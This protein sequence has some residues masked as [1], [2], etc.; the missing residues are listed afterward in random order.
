M[1]KIKR[2]RKGGND[3][4]KKSDGKRISGIIS[5]S[6]VLSFFDKLCTGAHEKVKTGLFAR[7]FCSYPE[8]KKVKQKL[9]K[10]RT[11]RSKV[12]EKIENSVLTAFFSKLLV[13]FIEC[14][15][16]VY[17]SFLFA[18]SAVSGV[19]TLVT[20]LM[21][22]RGVIPASSYSALIFCGAVLI[23]S[24]P[25]ISSRKTLLQG[26]K[27]SK[28][29]LKILPI[30]GFEPEKSTYENER[31]KSLVGLLIGILV[32]ALIVKISPFLIICGLLA[33]VYAIMVIC[34]PEFGVLCL[35]FVSP[36]L[37]TMPVA[38]LLILVVIS[39]FLKII[40]G[41][42][43]V[44]FETVDLFVLIF[45]GLTLFGGIV[46]LSLESLAPSLMRLCLILGFF[47]V[48]SVKQSR[49]WLKKYAISAIA[50]AV[51]VSLYGIL[52]YFIGSKVG[53]AWLDTSMFTDIS[54]RAIS[55]LENPN[56]LGEYLIMIIPIALASLISGELF[57]RSQIFFFTLIMGFCLIL[58]W[59]RGAW[60]GL[61][62]AA[63]IL[64]FIWHKRAMWLVFGSLIAFPLATFVMPSSILNRFMSIGNTADSSTLYRVN[65]WRGAMR[66][67]R[68]NIFTGI[69]IGE[70]A[71]GKIYPDY[72]LPGIEQAPHSHNLF[73][74]ITV[75]MGIIA[76]IVFLFVLFFTYQSGFTLFSKL[77]RS[78]NVDPSGLLSPASL[79]TAD[80]FKVK[81]KKHNPA[82]I[83]RIA[84]AGPLCGI[85]GVLVQ[86]TTDYS[87]YNYR[88][89][90]MFWL[91]LA[92]AVGY[93]KNGREFVPEENFDEV[94]KS[95][96]SSEIDISG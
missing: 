90:L 73:M 40:R 33:A 94:G 8:G 43:Q 29:L 72:T 35:F 80:E 23:A 55:T 37:P 56:M 78:D 81:N 67:I 30:I 57:K 76:L 18:F 91:V 51:F 93:T 16:K 7:I 79:K 31:G 47:V 70:G 5:N 20:G 25:L 64:L 52:M 38:A 69:G 88:V 50:S 19:Y 92:L 24:I 42:R 12:A 45:A 13:F 96:E 27:G 95:S 6:R 28:I 85:F 58:T 39:Y 82:L 77:S 54:G 87:W 53:G 86:G 17:G 26:V 68:D 59:S 10:S 66:M 11:F 63:V 9:K 49:D 34:R 14:R 15:L 62:F 41:K 48:A 22:P 2:K 75:E 1:L 4:M 21:T 89:Y 32:G 60:L 65:I 61:I 44:L 71:W 46:S 3:T 83:L 74:Q 36:I 84:V